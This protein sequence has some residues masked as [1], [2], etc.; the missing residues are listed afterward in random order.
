MIK[1]VKWYF[2]KKEL[3]T[4]PSV[5]QGLPL[6]TEQRYRR[7]GARFIIDLGSTMNLS[8]TTMATGVV[9]FHRFY[10]FHTFQ[11]FPRYV[12]LQNLGQEKY[13]GG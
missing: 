3:R 5:L 9:Y 7:E 10:M 11:D 6:E 8:L 12:S 13:K 1:M 2:E 4:T